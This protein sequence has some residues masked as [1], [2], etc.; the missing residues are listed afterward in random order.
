MIKIAGTMHD[1]KSVL[2]SGSKALL[3]LNISKFKVLISEI[4]N[5][6]L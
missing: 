3:L 2:I 1:M 4:R 5:T 6:N